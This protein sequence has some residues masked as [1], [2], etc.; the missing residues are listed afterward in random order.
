M[1]KFKKI[2]QFQVKLVINLQS[3]ENKNKTNTR[4]VDLK[5]SRAE[6]ISNGNE[7]TINKPEWIIVIAKID[8]LLKKK[9]LT[10]RE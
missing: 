9:K 3:Q 4:A 6:H 7:Q 10:K 2:G 5:K 8:K 1:L